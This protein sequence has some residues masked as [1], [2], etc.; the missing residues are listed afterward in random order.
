[1]NKR[2]CV[3]VYLYIYIYICLYVCVCVYV[4]VCARARPLNGRYS[5]KDFGSFNR[6][7]NSWNAMLR[8]ILFYRLSY[9]YI[10]ET[11][12]ESRR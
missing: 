11:F 2:V 12:K 9:I 7:K 10:L 4:C 1:V 3:C 5:N 6:D 8:V